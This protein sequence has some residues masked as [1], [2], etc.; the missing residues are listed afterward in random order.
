[1]VV[2]VLSFTTAVSVAVDAGTRVFPYRWRDESATAFAAQHGANLAVGRR[3]A[4]A[5]SPWT[6]S[7]ASLRAAPFMPR[8]VL[9]SPNGSAIA[10]SAGPTTACGLPWRT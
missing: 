7:P 9:P 6:L 2:D 10:A 4:S 3:A 8:L 5:T 1:M